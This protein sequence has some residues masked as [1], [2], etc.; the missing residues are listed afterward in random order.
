[1]SDES[2]RRD[3]DVVT[4]GS[5]MVEITPA[6]M[7]RSLADVDAMRPLPSGS[8]ANFAG[9]LAALGVA[10][11]MISR[12]GDDEL[13]GWI[14]DRLA[15][16]GI[17]TRFVRPVEGQL[18]PVSFAW[19]NQDG[20]KTFYFY[21]FPGH[22]DPMATLTAKQI[23]RSEV[24]A[25]GIFDF[26]EA[27]IRHEPLRSAAMT[28]A[29]MAAE[30]GCRVCYAANYRRAAWQGQSMSEVVEVQRAACSSA[31]IVVMNQEE[32]AIVTSSEDGE[33]QLHEIARL[34]PELVAITR[35]EDGT[36]VLCEDEVQFVPARAVRV[37]YDIGAGDTFHA[38]LIAALLSGMT[39]FEAARFGSDAAAARI[40]RPAD[41]PDPGFDEIRN[42]GRVDD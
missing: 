27:T 3:L 17:D 42:I 24:T 23:D 22:C 34:G 16:R 33:G 26:T 1:M 35:G 32:A 13:G 21:R 31:Q 4:I 41:A 2:G 36:L 10:V 25:G 12:V 7:G 6:E 8:A 18:T 9:A 19:M 11:G 29:R 5:A 14:S 37:V 39:G 38:G 28:A 40:S 30:D 20:E 15:S